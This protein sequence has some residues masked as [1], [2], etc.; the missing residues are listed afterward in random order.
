[1]RTHCARS[2]ISW[3]A[4]GCFGGIARSALVRRTA[5]SSRLLS[6]SPGSTTGPLSP[7]RRTPARLSSSSPPRRVFAAALWH[8]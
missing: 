2:S 1:M 7:P 4:S 8:S 3:A 5:A 6:G